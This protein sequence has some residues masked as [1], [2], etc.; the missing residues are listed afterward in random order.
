MVDI[1]RPRKE[2]PL[3]PAPRPPGDLPPPAPPARRSMAPMPAPARMSQRP[4]ER[5]QERPMPPVPRKSVVLRPPEPMRVEHHERHGIA[6]DIED[7]AGSPPVFIKVD[8][9]A[10][11]VKNLHKLKSYSLSLRDALDAL[12]DIEKEITT[13]IS[14]AHRALDDFN[15]I[16]SVLD[17][18]IV[19]ADSTSRID[20]DSPEDV[21]N[22]VKNI[23]EQMEKIKADLRSAGK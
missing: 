2:M 9:Y 13:G 6:R 7:S 1:P 23:Y 3:P 21:D 22:Y 15:T 4:Q 5:V 8:K 18:K 11:I 19:R 10:D 12:S 17:S 14:I 16:I 20:V